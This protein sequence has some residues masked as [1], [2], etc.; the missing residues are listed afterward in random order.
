MS[1]ELTINGEIKTAMLAK[2]EATLRGLRAIKSAILLAKTADGQQGELSEADEI[3]I[4]QKLAKQRKD[5][6]EVFVQQHR[7]D[8]AQKEREELE[9][10]EKFLPKAMDAEELK[11][12]LKEIIAAVGATSKADM[13]KVMGVA[14]KQLAGQADGK[15][16]NA[17]VSELLIA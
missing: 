15:T 12:I 8:L 4:L 6:L 9:V 11:A 7:E 3:K 5:S 1:L 17:M 10:I 2:Q 13:G 16:I 14:S